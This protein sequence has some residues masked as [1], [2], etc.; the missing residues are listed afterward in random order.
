MT[1][2]DD[3][4][5]AAVAREPVEPS[6]H[7]T[8]RCAKHP[9][10]IVER[11]AIESVPLT[12]SADKQEK[13][14]FIAADFLD[15]DE[16]SGEIRSDDGPAFRWSGMRREDADG[17]VAVKRITLGHGTWGKDLGVRE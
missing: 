6:A 15:D 5:H 10:E 8:V 7:A 14:R 9:H 1:V 2:L 12:E 17:R 11:D 4:L 16:E 3:V 13:E